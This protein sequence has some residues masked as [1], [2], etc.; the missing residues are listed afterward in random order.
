MQRDSIAPKVSVG[1]PVYNGERYLPKA[2]ESILAQTYGNLELIISDNA[3]TERTQEICRHYAERDA[4]VRYY[5]RPVNV[6]AAPN[7]NRVFALAEASKY[8]KWAAHDDWIAPKYLEEC[9][10]A[11]EEDPDAVLCQSLVGIMD[12]DGQL[13][14]H[15]S[16]LGDRHRGRRPGANRHDRDLRRWRQVASPRACAC[17]RFLVVT[18][19]LFP[20]DARRELLE[21][22]AGSSDTAGRARLICTLAS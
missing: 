13:P 22:R 8:F 10:K 14:R 3:S 18:Q 17:G 7:F 2:I 19:S 15:V 6:G 20:P 12:A 4:R 1:L 16:S 11:L 5:R 9:V 21:T